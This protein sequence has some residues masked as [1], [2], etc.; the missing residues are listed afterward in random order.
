MK[1][2]L[3]LLSTIILLSIVGCQ[4]NKPPLGEIAAWEKPGADFTEVG[5]ALLECGMPTPYDVDPESRKLS[6]NAK[7]SIDACMIQAGFRDKYE[8][9]GGGWCYTF[10][11]KNL[12]ICRPGAVIPQRSVKRRLNSPFCKQ[13]PEQYEC[14][15]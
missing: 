7:A 11:E 1:Q 4:F 13:H 2:I 9:K 3:K 14:Y 15:P 6:I 8:M 12:P 10:R 5:K